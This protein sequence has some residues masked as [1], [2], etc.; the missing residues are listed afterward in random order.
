MASLSLSSTQPAG[1]AQF[2]KIFDFLRNLNGE[3]LFNFM[4]EEV[5]RHAGWDGVAQSVGR[6][7]ADPAWKAAFE[8]LPEAGPTKRKSCI[9]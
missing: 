5:N 4:A 6:F 2:G 1:N 8:A 7:L 9:S 3:F